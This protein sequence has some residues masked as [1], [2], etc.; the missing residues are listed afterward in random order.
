MAQVA[1]AITAIRTI[2]TATTA[3]MATT[4]TTTITIVALE[5]VLEVCHLVEVRIWR[6]F[7]VSKCIP[8]KSE[9]WTL[10]L[11][12]WEDLEVSESWARRKK[13]GENGRFSA[14]LNES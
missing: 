1:T 6:R 8:V 9:A 4:I 11:E 5:L 14:F 10:D 7:K 12:E 2:A 13:P 3:T